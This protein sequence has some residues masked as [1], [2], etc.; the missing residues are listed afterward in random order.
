MVLLRWGSFKI[1]QPPTNMRTK[2]PHNWSRSSFSRVVKRCHVWDRAFRT[3]VEHALPETGFESLDESLLSSTRVLP[4]RI[5]LF[6]SLSFS[7]S[8]STAYIP[9]SLLPLTQS[10][11]VRVQAGASSVK[12]TQPA[13]NGRK[14]L[15]HYIKKLKE[16]GYPEKAAD[17]Q[18]ADYT[19]RE[20]DALFDL[21]IDE[22]DKMVEDSF[23]EI[24]TFTLSND[25][26]KDVIQDALKAS[27]GGE[28][29][30][31]LG[32]KADY[33]GAQDVLLMLGLAFERVSSK[34]SSGGAKG[35]D[36][37]KYL[38][39]TDA[40]LSKFDKDCDALVTDIESHFANAMKPIDDKIDHWEKEFKVWETD[41][42][43]YTDM[44][45]E[46][47]EGLDQEAFLKSF[48][49]YTDY[50]DTWNNDN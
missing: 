26:V 17:K 14:V 42:V 22:Y 20:L 7:F 47:P 36:G 15:A 21:T 40:Q 10:Y 19:D 24:G 9:S 48:P 44:L 28:K 38:F 3:R 49:G 32:I 6:L 18:F 2:R 27:E 8:S 46:I 5:S 4:C 11:T 13:G 25:D 23:N 35:A 29:A 1:S 45:G 12:G 31:P 43:K 33:G 30:S 50:A 41:P 34:M 37:T 16:G 39:M